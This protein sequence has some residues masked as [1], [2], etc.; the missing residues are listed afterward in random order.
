MV[1]ETPDGGWLESKCPSG[2]AYLVAWEGGTVMPGVALSSRTLEGVDSATMVTPLPLIA[3]MDAGRL[4]VR[5]G[6]L[7][8]GPHLGL[9][10]CDGSSIRRSDDEIVLFGVWVGEEPGSDPEGMTVVQLQG[11]TRAVF[12]IEGG[13]R[14]VS[15]LSVGLSAG[16]VQKRGPS[17]W[18]RPRC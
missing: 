15:G 16:G 3:D 9:L 11:G 12:D 17:D 5:T 8:A 10:A 14:G 4:E 13:D 18:T 6:R 2:S 7:E 1:F